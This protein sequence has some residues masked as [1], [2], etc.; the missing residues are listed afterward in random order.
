MMALIISLS[1]GFGFCLQKWGSIPYGSPLLWLAM[2]LVFAV[3]FALSDRFLRFE[4]LD[5]T[6][7]SFSE[8]SR[9]KRYV[10][11]TFLL[12]FAVWLFFLLCAYPG[13]FNYDA[14]TQWEM[15]TLGEVTAHHPILHT[16]L[17][18]LLLHMSYTLFGDP[19]VGCFLYCLIQILITDLALCSMLSF[20]A[21]RKLPRR[22][23]IGAS[24]FLAFLPT[25]IA[26]VLSVTKD[27]LFAPFFVLF[28]LQTVKAFAEEDF[29]DG[30][31]NMVLWCISAFFASLLR[32]NAIYILVPF[33]VFLVIRLRKQ[34][35]AWSLVCVLLSIVLFLGPITDALTVDG[36]SEKEYLSVPIQQVMRVYH[37]HRAELDPEDVALVEY[38][39]SDG[40]ETLNSALTGYVPKIADNAKWGLNRDRYEEKQAE[41][42]DLWKRWGLA[43]PG[44]YLN[45]FL[46]LNYGFWYPFGTL[47]LYADGSEGYYVCRSYGPVWEDFKI[48]AIG[49][50]FRQFEYN[51]LLCRN[52]LT[53]W[54]FAPGT[55]FLVMLLAFAHLLY[56]R[57]KEA[58]GLVLVC[59]VWLTFL[60]GPVALVRY[61]GFLYYLLPLELGLIPGR[62]ENDGLENEIEGI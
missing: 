57:R 10:K 28:T 35:K 12:T 26:I 14:P 20:L 42:L 24:C 47:A 36:V 53:M 48:E 46:M 44:E 32:N 4:G 1:M 51:S 9:R 5:G 6:S 39:F 56:H 21:K 38:L 58:I 55:Y 2:A 15:Y 60:L 45:A 37:L 49:S 40:S 23:L 13:F 16:Y 27:S 61:V 7:Q 29:F 22:F 19:K 17:I 33:L 50:K 43:Y 52:P 3:A 34:R 8:D 11:V 31:K 59:L 18:S 54:L 30:W 41:A 25:N 62:N